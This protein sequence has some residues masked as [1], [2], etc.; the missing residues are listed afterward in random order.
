MRRPLGPRQYMFKLRAEQSI[1]H[2]HV[3]LYASLP[4]LPSL[5]S[6]SSEASRPRGPPKA[7]VSSSLPSLT[8]PIP[9]HTPS[10]LQL[11]LQSRG[12]PGKDGSTAQESAYTPSLSPSPFL[13]QNL[14]VTQLRP[15]VDFVQ[16]LGPP[17]IRDSWKF[18][19]Q[20]PPSAPRPPL[21]KNSH[22]TS[23]NPSNHSLKPQRYPS[24][25]EPEQAVSSDDD[26]PPFECSRR[27]L[28]LH[29]PG[30]SDDEPDK[31]DG[32]TVVDPGT[33]LYGKSADIHL[34]GPTVFWKHLHIME[35]TPPAPQPETPPSD[36]G[37]F[38]KVRRPIFWGSPFS[39][40]DY[41]FT[42]SYVIAPASSNSHQISSGN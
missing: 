1:L 20:P 22:P 40:S 4:I 12:P 26:D 13:N 30:Y 8:S 15:E 29:T 41:P 7:C 3:R 19:A 35:V 6:P 10:L 2:L 11:C 18:D 14:P 36:P 21:S 37:T 9:T 24:D 42:L 25:D 33:R 31:D 28:N 32:D 38:P 17:I 34:V 16:Y 39:V 23:L 27:K 5:S